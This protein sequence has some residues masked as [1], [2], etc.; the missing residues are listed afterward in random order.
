MARPPRVLAINSNQD[1]LDAIQGLLAAEGYRCDLGHVRAL[2]LGETT[3]EEMFGPDPVDA[4]LFDI[5]PP[6]DANWSYF[7]TFEKH[8]RVVDV[9]IILTTTNIAALQ[10]VAQG[11]PSLEVMLKPFDVELLLRLAGVATGRI[12]DEELWQRWFAGKPS[13]H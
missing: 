13:V 12:H 8:P 6:M 7:L 5:A 9:P 11:R 4:I 3:V 10:G 1:V 2:R